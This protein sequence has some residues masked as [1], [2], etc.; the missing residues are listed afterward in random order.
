MR[1]H[2]IPAHMTDTISPERLR[3]ALDASEEFALVDTR[4][5]GDF[6]EWR[7]PGAVNYPF[8]S[9]DALDADAFREATGVEPD[10]RVVTVCAK[11]I[12]SH[13][14]ADELEG[15]GF[16]NVTVVEGGMEGWSAVYEVAAVETADPGV[17]TSDPAIEIFQVQRRAKGCLGYV[18]GSPATGEA[19]VVDPT[20]HVEE[21]LDVARDAGYEVTRV[22]DTHVHADHISGG[23][24][25]ADE[26]GAPYHLGAGAADRG[27]EYDY[28]PLA[29]NEVVEVGDVAVKT[30]FAPGHTSEMVSYLVE[31]E[32]L[33][34]GDTLFVDSVGRTELQFAADGEDDREAAAG[35]A[36]SLWES[37]HRTVL[38][39]PDAVSVLPG[40]FTVTGTGETPG[41]TPGEPVVSTVGRRRTGSDLLGLSVEAFVDRVLADLPEKPPNYG[42]IVDINAGRAAP[43]SEQRA[44]ELELGPNRCAAG[45]EGAAGD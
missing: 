8:S 29:R 36:R 14:F 27:V 44:V 18:V 5:A 34:T 16:G 13:D 25:L 11:G 33:L 45:G 6:A 19:A 2:D 24:E 38:A 35:G 42:T 15:A 32:A 21:F 23:R 20:R 40:H 9:D 41:V 4:P 3:D 28:E 22:L 39:E 17:G 31:R 7:V 12:S 26:T 30:V 43:G 10:D 1:S 37:L